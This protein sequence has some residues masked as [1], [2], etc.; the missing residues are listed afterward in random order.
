MSAIHRFGAECGLNDVHPVS[1]VE[2]I[3]SM[4]MRI[5]VR[6]LYISD[7]QRMKRVL[8]EKRRK[9]SKCRTSVLKRLNFLDALNGSD[10]QDT[11][12]LNEG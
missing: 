3:D 5:P 1:F 11:S 10:I 2:D 7:L 8:T 6:P 12:H 9:G 4:G